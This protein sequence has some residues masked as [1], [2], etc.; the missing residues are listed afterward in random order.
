MMG[1][2]IA[3]TALNAA[4]ID[5][6]VTVDTAD[7]QKKFM[8]FD[9]ADKAD[10]LAILD[11]GG[12]STYSKL[13]AKAYSSDGAKQFATTSKTSAKSGYLSDIGKGESMFIVLLDTTSANTATDGMAYK[14]TGTIDGTAYIYDGNAD[15][16]EASPGTF[17]IA[18][19]SFANSGTIGGSGSVPEP[20][21]G[22]L[23]LLGIAGLALKRK[24]A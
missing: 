4:S 3:A 12:A 11:A 2:V 20:T 15:P 9:A 14:Y 22:L 17:N 8:F 16:P 7:R 19:S 24:H 23:V 18:A 10:V 5:W 1:T 21:S 13:Q 6:K